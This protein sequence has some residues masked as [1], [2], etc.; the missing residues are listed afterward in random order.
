MGDDAIDES[1]GQCL[2]GF[3][4]PSGEIKLS[5]FGGA[6]EAGQK[7]AATKIARK[8]DPDKSGHQPCRSAGDPAIAS[9][10][11]SKPG[12]GGRAFPERHGFTVLVGS[13]RP[14]SRGYILLRNADPMAHP[15]IFPEYF[16]EPEDLHAL[17]RSVMQMRDMMRGSAIS[18]LIEVEL[19]PGQIA[20]DQESI[21]AD[22]RA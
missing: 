11:Q 13:G 15:L 10:R 18:H 5:C 8:S 4:R 21:E 9:K 3:D 19:A 7:V 17:A 2:V 20:N 22:I 6:D 12:T 16:S 1:E 14:L